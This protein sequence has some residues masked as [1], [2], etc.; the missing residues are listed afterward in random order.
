MNINEIARLAGVSR[1]TVS[2]YLNNGYV[3]SEKGSH[4]Q[5]NPGDRISAILPG[6]DTADQ[7]PVSSVS[8]FQRSIQIP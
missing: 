8:S 7:K 6:T 4:P 5:G 2:R 1:A 3:S